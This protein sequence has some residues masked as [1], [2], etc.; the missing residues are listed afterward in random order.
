[1]S[2]D[3]TGNFD[4][5]CWFINRRRVLEL[6]AASIEHISPTGLPPGD[7]HLFGLRQLAQFKDAVTAWLQ[8]AKPPTLGRLVVEGKAQAGAIFT[9]YSNWF[10][11]G[12]P[13]VGPAARSGT[14]TARMAFA[15]SKL[16]G[17]LN[18]GKVSFA[19]NPEH[20][21]SN[22]AWGELSGQ[23]RMFVLG[24]IQDVQETEIRAVPYVVANPLPVLGRPLSTVGQFLSSHGEVHI[25]HID[26]FS[27]VSEVP[28]RRTVKTLDPLRSIP[29]REI[30][31]A[32]GEIIGEATV[33]KDWGGEQSDLYSDIVQIGGR[34]F[35]TAF[36]FKGPAKFRPMTHAELGKNGD[37]I[38]RLF[39]EPAV[40][41]VLQHCH[42]I[43]PAIR[44]TMRAFA[45][46]FGTPRL[47]C[48]IDGYDTLRVLKAYGKCG[49]EG[50]NE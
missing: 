39:A 45:T 29:E 22:S 47:F 41:C 24:V 33:P 40:L 7:I 42:E 5:T 18:G 19:F 16:D 10:F 14:S 38:V 35:N 43:T 49:F 15:Y 8:K 21:T 9:H 34:R 46:G 36:A 3:A 1:M 12:L 20:L 28:L 6:T 25:D 48:L 13:K 37:Q 50:E 17:L 44:T 11:K 30:K 2:D 27:R 4:L 31:Q 23:K 32:F 26:T